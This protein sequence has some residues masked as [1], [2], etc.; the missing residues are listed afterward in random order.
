MAKITLTFMGKDV[1]TSTSEYFTSPTAA[2]STGVLAAVNGLIYV[3]GTQIALITAMKFT[4][5][6]NMSSES[7]VGSNTVPD[8]FEGSVKVSGE[9]TAF[10]EDGT[11]RDYFL[12][13]TEVS[14]FS[15]FTTGSTAAADFV[16]FS[17]PRVKMG[18]SSK[19]DGQ[20]G[21]V[22]TI[23][24]QALYNSVGGAGTSSE[25]TTL[26]IQDSQA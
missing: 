23:P 22:Q 18:G 20:K 25:Q 17:F 9:V 2:T 11:L 15:A 12:N 21:I 6:G 19:D 4:I 1:T 24:F 14:I 7:V 8:I 13:E 5:D 16:S 3:N 26:V 10:F